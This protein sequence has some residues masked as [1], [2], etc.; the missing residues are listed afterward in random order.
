VRGEE[1]PYLFGHGIQFK[2]VKWPT[3]WYDVH[4]VLDALSR[5]PDLWR[6]RTA[7]P[8]DRIALAELAA[9]MIAYNVDPG[10]RVTPRSCYRGFEGFSFGQK[11]APSAFATARLASVLRRLEGLAP[12]IRAVDVRKLSSSKGGSGTAVPPKARSGD[13]PSKSAGMLS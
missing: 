11:K 2:T 1:K 12:E 5:Y 3:F 6:G 8:E 9:C 4:W 7:R 10:G 13:R